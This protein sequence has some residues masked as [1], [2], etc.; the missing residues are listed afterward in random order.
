MTDYIGKKLY[1]EFHIRGATHNGE[2]IIDGLNTRLEIWSEKPIFL[3]EEKTLEMLTG[4][5]YTEAKTITLIDNIQLNHGCNSLRQGDDYITRHFIIIHPRFVLLGSTYF[6]TTKKITSFGFSTKN[7]GRL[8]FDHKASRKII[9]PQIN[10]IKILIK[11]DTIKSKELYNIDCESDDDLINERNFPSV[12]I[13]G[14]EREILFTSLEAYSIRI[15]HYE[16]S[17]SLGGQSIRSMISTAFNVEL[18]KQIQIKEVISICWDLLTFIKFISGHED[19][20]SNLHICVESDDQDEYFDVI[21]SSEAEPTFENH[22]D[23]LLNIYMDKCVI[24]NILNNWISRHDKWINARGQLCLSYPSNKYSIDRLTKSANVF[25]LIPSSSDKIELNAD[26]KS[27][28]DQAKALFNSLPDSHEKQSIINALSR[29]GTKTLKH[30]IKERIDI[31]ENNSSLRLNNI[32]FVS[33]HCV[34]CRNYYV[35]GGKSKINYNIEYEIIPFFI[36]TLDFIFVVSDFIECGWNIDEW[37]SQHMT[38]NKVSNYITFYEHNL[39]KLMQ[40]T[41]KRHN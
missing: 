10:D 34:D 20:I 12:Y 33:D 22:F 9:H 6:N 40:A 2:L 25:D 32:R 36:D 4:F 37:L 41:T 18:K 13:Y 1:G 21:I 7:L 26:I 27:A 15:Y 29:L 5:L 11:N 30:K 39:N 24:S 3:T 17:S 31:I 14:G 16:S 23:G 38:N 8:F 28:K 35:H 19:E